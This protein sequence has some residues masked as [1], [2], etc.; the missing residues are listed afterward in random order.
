MQKHSED[1]YAIVMML[2]L[3]ALLLISLSTALST[4]YALHQQNITA[5]K[6]LHQHENKLNQ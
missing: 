2:T 5:E 4:L 6:E 3:A 1:G